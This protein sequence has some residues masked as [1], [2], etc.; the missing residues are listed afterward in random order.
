[1][2]LHAAIVTFFGVYGCAR[3][4]VIFPPARDSR[5]LGRACVGAAS[6]QGSRGASWRLLRGSGARVHGG[7]HPSHVTV[8]ADNWESLCVYVSHLCRM[9][10]RY[11]IGQ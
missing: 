6:W 10:V 4:E 2:S 8:G 7:A 1:M 11:V 3:G 9:H 5:R